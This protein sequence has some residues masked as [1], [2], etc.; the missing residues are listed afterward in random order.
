MEKRHN[1]AVIA[2]SGFNV[3]GTVSALS[4]LVILFSSSFLL[5][6]VALSATAFSFFLFRNS[7]RVANEFNDSC[8]LSVCDGKVESVEELTDDTY[9]EGGCYQV[10]IQNSLL[11]NGH[12]RTPFNALVQEQT[13]VHG[14]SLPMKKRLASFLNER[15][16]LS[17]KNETREVKVEHMCSKHNIALLQDEKDKVA[18][19]KRYGF[20][21]EGKT[22]IYLPKTSRVAVRVGQKI[23]ASETILAYFNH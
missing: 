13:L 12:F 21:L 5:K 11:D 8:V 2:K 20:M 9:F 19:G 7:E 23:R 3:V 6:L 18:C 4:L 10:S 17:F 14:C 22:T 1:L 16:M 15:A